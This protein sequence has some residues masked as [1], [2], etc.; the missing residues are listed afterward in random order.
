MNPNSIEYISKDWDLSDFAGYSCPGWYFWDETWSN[1]Y[2]PFNSKNEAKI[3]LEEY[4]KRF[5]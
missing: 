5:L 3:H 2:G 1:C 4:I